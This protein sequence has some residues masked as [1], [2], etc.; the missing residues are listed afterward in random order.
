MH[1]HLNVTECSASVLTAFSTSKGLNLSLTVFGNHCE[2]LYSSL[3]MRWVGVGT[4]T[5]SFIKHLDGREACCGASNVF[6]CMVVN[7][8]PTN[9]GF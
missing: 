5:E 4:D 1:T 8:G 2:F 9:G 3:F 6:R 7:G